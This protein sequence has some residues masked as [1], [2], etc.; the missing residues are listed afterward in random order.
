MCAGAARAGAARA[1]A[2]A[3]ADADAVQ[4]DTTTYK[5]YSCAISRVYLNPLGINCT[6][7]AVLHWVPICICMYIYTA[8]NVY[9]LH[10]ILAI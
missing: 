5:L 8:A 6:R 10:R 1:G 2:G 4:Y 7:C 3:G 9:K